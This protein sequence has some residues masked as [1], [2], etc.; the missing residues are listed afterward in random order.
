MALICALFGT[1]TIGVDDFMRDF[2]VASPN[3][4]EQQIIADFL[5]REEAD[6]ELTLR[7]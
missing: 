1:N 2:A 5:D 7:E 3:K 4:A 6:V